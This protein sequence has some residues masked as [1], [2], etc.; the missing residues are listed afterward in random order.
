MKSHFLFHFSERNIREVS[1]LQTDRN[2]PRAKQ[3]VS[4]AEIY[5]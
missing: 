3:K 5:F 4:S 1:L 2:T